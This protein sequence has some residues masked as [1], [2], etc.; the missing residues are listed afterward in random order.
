MD[1]WRPLEAG[2]AAV[3][4]QSDV[5]LEAL[6]DEEDSGRP[7]PIDIESL[8]TGVIPATLTLSGIFPTFCCIDF[9]Y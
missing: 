5:I 8:L 7:K 4:S 6:E 3:G 2:L 9:V 1:R